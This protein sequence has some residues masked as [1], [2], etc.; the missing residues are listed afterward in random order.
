VVRFRPT[1][2]QALGRGAYLGS[3]GGLVGALAAL[4]AAWAGLTDRLDAPAW[5]VAVAALL[6]GVAAGA[7]SGLVFGRDA[8]A[9][10]DDNG[11]HPLPPAGGG[12]TPWQR[13]TD[14]RA[15]RHGWRTHVA[16]H[17][18]SGQI[19]RLVAPY[20]GPMAARDP[21]FERKLFMLRHLWETHRSFVLPHHAPGS[22]GV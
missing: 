16:V 21:E 11:I 15:E 22:D 2:A 20:D 17:L 10:V 6:L 3:L 14:L 9:D 7:L 5:S 18:D 12:H 8:G 4:L 19:V 1:A 13:I